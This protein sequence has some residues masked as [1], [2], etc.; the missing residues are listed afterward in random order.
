MCK[1]TYSKMYFHKLKVESHYVNS[2]LTLYFAAAGTKP[3]QILQNGNFKGEGKTYFTF[4][5]SQWNQ[6]FF[7][8]ILG[9]FFWSI[10]HEI[11]IKCQGQQAFS[12]YV[13]N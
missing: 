6:T 4:N 1:F 5:V 13:K 10:H 8:V 3:Q 9:R 2:K 11:Y 12:H 7:H